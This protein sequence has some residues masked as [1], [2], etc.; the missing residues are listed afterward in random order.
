MWRAG[1]R[2]AARAAIAHLCG[3]AWREPRGINAGCSAAG[4]SSTFGSVSAHAR[5]VGRQGAMR[6]ATRS[7]RHTRP[8]GGRCGVA[9]RR[10][11]RAQQTNAG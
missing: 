5:P 1:G 6:L 8:P 10:A 4:R 7:R 3:A 9:A 11:W 2:R